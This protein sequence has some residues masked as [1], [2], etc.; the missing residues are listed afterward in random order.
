MHARPAAVGFIL[1]TVVID[2][3]SFGVLIPVLPKLVEEFMGGDTAR[4][5]QVYGV[6]GTAWA[7]MQFV[8]APLHGMLSDRFGR[9]PLILLSC[10]GMGLDFVL[11]AL[12]P[13]LWW[14][15][16]GRLISGMLA[17][18]IA[19]ASAY[20]ADVTPPDRRAAAF[21]MIGAAWGFGFVV[22]PALGGLLGDY[23]ARLPFWVAAG[24]CGVNAV[25]GFFVLPESLPRERRAAFSWRKAN[26]LGSLALLRAH[27]G[28][29]RLA[30]VNALAAL[31]HLVFPS[32]F[33]LYAG[34]RYGWDAGTVG[35]T[36]TMVGICGIVV[37]AVLVKK[38]VAR[39]GE[40]RTLLLG[41]AFAAA[42]YC[43]IG[44]APSSIWVWIGVVLLSPAG[45]WTAAVQGLMTRRVGPDAQG[46]LQGANSSVQGVVGMIGPVL[47][48]LA[49]ALFIDPA[50][51][52][53]PGAPFFLATLLALLAL[54]LAARK[55]P[56]TA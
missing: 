45:L 11:M 41:L 1:V 19:T 32:V 17:A 52:A 21:G 13:S 35:L 42:E 39:L 26:P 16:A 36:L 9:R 51:G 50:R 40:H 46:Q 15:F 5:A 48:T 49:L 31:A 56:E 30:T 47:C 55:T 10:L 54:A 24:L 7:L 37:Q 12:A 6:F 33:V 8:C 27:R 18:S 29:L 44:L 20:I 4:A 3:L 23:S 28:L 38:A 25:Y 22:G 34:Y 43:W 53:L 14:L 2:V